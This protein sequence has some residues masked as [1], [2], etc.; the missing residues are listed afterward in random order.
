MFWAE[1][2][3][4]HS[5]V[6]RRGSTPLQDRASQC[7][8]LCWG[9][10]TACSACFLGFLA[11]LLARS[12][13][14]LCSG[15]LEQDVM[16]RY[17]TVERPAAVAMA[18]AAAMSWWMWL[19]GAARMRAMRHGTRLHDTASWMC[20]IAWGLCERIRRQVERHR[21]SRSKTGCGKHFPSNAIARYTSVPPLQ[22]TC[23]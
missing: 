23:E 7:G 3:A 2:R 13:A 14:F 5:L 1:A 16:Q 6:D 19:G 15:L 20:Y 18:A 17:G 12:L 21:R 9:W 10:S 11:S 8:L 22:E 4:Q